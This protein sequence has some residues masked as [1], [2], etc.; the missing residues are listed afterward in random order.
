MLIATSVVSFCKDGRCSVNP[1]A[2]ELLF[3][4]LAHPVYKM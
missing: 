2:L 3:L 1:L 4:T